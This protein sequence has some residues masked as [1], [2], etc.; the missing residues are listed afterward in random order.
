[1]KKLLGI[2]VLSLLWCNV[3]FAEV[4]QLP[5]GTTV[6]DLLKDGYRLSSTDAV[7][8]DSVGTRMIYNL[9]KNKTLITCVLGQ[10]GETLSTLCIKP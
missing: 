7:Y 8:A 6:N 3:S 2:V 4:E 10:H 1:M 5:L 9:I